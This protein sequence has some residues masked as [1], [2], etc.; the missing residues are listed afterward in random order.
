LPI[1]APCITRLC[2]N[3]RA[4]ARVQGRRS[5][6]FL[7]RQ[8]DQPR[9]AVGCLRTWRVFL[10]AMWWMTRRLAAGISYSQPGIR[11]G[12][13]HLGTSRQPLLIWPSWGTPAGPAHPATGALPFGT[14]RLAR[15]RVERPLR[16]PH[17][18]VDKLEPAHPAGRIWAALRPILRDF[19]SI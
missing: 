19:E 11:S 10:G 1:S 6:C 18:T 14:T 16:A 3:E 5:A 15:W 9:D 17:D 12:I 7:A 4:D 8:K 2:D 13:T